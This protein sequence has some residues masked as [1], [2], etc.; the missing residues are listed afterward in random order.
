MECKDRKCEICLVDQ[1][2]HM[3]FPFREKMIFTD[4][5]WWHDA[6]ETIEVCG[7][8]KS[9]VFKIKRSNGEA[10]SECVTVADVCQV[11]RKAF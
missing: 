6:D 2:R 7:K 1:A 10:F 3:W 5:N 9:R 11:V 8:C 4:L